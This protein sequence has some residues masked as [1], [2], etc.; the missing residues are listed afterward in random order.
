M[1]QYQT[2]LDNSEVGYPKSNFLEH[3]FG[4]E[5]ATRTIDGQKR[6]D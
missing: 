5:K 6:V 1:H 3:R 4:F 2:E